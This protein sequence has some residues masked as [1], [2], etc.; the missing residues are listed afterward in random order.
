MEERT[1]SCHSLVPNPKTIELPRDEVCRMEVTA[2][3]TSL[4][5]SVYTSRARRVC[6]LILH[7]LSAPLPNPEPFYLSTVAS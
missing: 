3:I 7:G 6:A 4:W 1:N 2:A 5:D